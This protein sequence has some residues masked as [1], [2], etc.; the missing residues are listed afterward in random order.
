[1]EL[2]TDRARAQG[3]AVAD[4]AEVRELCQR[5]EGIPLA[6]ELAAGRLRALS[7]RSCCSAWTTGSGC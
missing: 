2:F 6:L 1:M 7:P 3:V 5:L 4:G